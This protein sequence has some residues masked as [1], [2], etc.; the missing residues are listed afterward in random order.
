MYAMYTMLKKL[1]IHY[2]L[3]VSAMH[4]RSRAL[5]IL[6]FRDSMA[7]F[8]NLWASQWTLWL[9]VLAYILPF[10]NSTHT[11]FVSL[12]LSLSLAIDF[13]TLGSNP[14]AKC[15]LVS[16]LNLYILFNRIHFLHVFLILK[17]SFLRFIAKWW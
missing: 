6:P 16:L 15:I 14:I 3:R 11:L 10:S 9:L 12:S 8:H 4:C 5:L 7:I 1:Y 13:C 17:K 2:C